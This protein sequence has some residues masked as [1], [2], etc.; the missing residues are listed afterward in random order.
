MDAVKGADSTAEFTP[1]VSGLKE[2]DTTNVKSKIKIHYEQRCLLYFF[3]K[4]KKNWITRGK[5]NIRFEK[6]ADASY[7]QM[8]LY[9]EKTFKLR[10]CSMIPPDVKLA[11]NAGSDRAWTFACTDYSEAEDGTGGVIQS[12]A[13][14]FK[15]SDIADKFK[16]EFE[17]YQEENKKAAA[18]SK[19]AP[20]E[21][22]E[23]AKK[24]EAKTEAAEEKAT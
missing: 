1:V 18:A 17:K 14:K 5:G 4:E 23:E 12:C 20:K 7:Y 24:E 8:V 10:L 19:S 21:Q 9:E 6:H 15:N 11:P 2:V 22:K 16:S 3:S 13:I